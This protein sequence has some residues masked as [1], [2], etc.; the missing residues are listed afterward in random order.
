MDIHLTV[1][2]IVELLKRTTLTSVIVEGKDDMTIYR[3]LE[4]KIGIDKANFFPCGGR[5][6]LLKVFER[7]DEFSHIKTVFLADKDSFIYSEVPKEYSDILWTV[8]YSIENDLYHGKFLEKLLTVNEEVNFRTSLKNFIT[9]YAFEVEQFNKKFVF[10]FSNHPNRVIDNA[11]QLDIKFL[12]SVNYK[13]PSIEIIAYLEREYD[14]LI[15]GKS[16]FALLL[17]FLSYK[18]RETKH[19]KKSLCETSF[20]LTENKLLKNLMTEIERRLYA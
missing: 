15:R 5:D 16:L 10:N 3:W 6:T 11:H 18:N 8:G 20:K 19:S 1:D 13:E 14:L 2:E 17:R 7:R 12:E 9:Y 4:E